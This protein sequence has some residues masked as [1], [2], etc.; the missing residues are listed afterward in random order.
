MNFLPEMDYSDY[1][2]TY[3]LEGLT[4]S[5]RMALTVY[6]IYNAFLAPKKLLRL[7]EN[8]AAE[9]T[10]KSYQSICKGLLNE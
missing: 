9:R 10:Y 2:K 7:C 6:S 4:K 3:W 1:E 5:I 8:V